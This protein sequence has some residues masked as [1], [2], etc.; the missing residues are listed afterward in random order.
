MDIIWSGCIISNNKEKVNE[1]HGN[2]LVLSSSH[3]R[4]TNLMLF[5]IV[6]KNFCFCFRATQL[7]YRDTNK[8]FLTKPC[9]G[10]VF[11]FILALQREYYADRNTK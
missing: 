6:E 9:L 8:N 1:K 2:K 3:Y 5:N 11:N 4:E 7:V 10:L